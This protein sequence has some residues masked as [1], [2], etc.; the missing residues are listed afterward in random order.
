RYAWQRNPRGT[1]TRGLPCDAFINF[2]ENHDQVANSLDGRR[3]RARTSPGLHRA[4]TALLLLMPGIPML[5]Q[6]Q[7]FGS[8]APFQY[9]AD[10]SPELAPRV[11]AG[12]ADFLAQFPSLAPEH[13]RMRVPPPHDPATF[14]RSRLDWAEREANKDLV[15]LHADLIVLRHTGKAWL[16]GPAVDGAALNDTAFV[17]RYFAAA[18]G[19][20]RLL[21]V[22][23]G[24]DIVCG[25]LAEPLVAPP[26]G[27]TWRTA[28]S[29]ED[30]GYG[31]SGAAGPVE[32]DG[33][34]IAGQA[35]FLLEPVDGGGGTEQA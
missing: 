35:A 25:S 2:L 20:E 30:P 11:Q 16:N 19:D 17:L 5:F 28:W 15:R 24:R 14:E 29:S 31:G 18:P 3:L 9:F 13:M 22:N 12:R 21:I 32:A 33:W 26:D 7:E 23:F 27:C 8:S 10:L 1:S 34:R 4:A 6:G